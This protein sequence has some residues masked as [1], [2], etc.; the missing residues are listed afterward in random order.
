MIGG[1]RVDIRISDE[2]YQDFFF[3]FL[4]NPSDRGLSIKLRTGKFTQSSAF[5]V[6]GNC[7]AE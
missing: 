5:Y 4:E 6:L 3:F 1:S 2:S 7:V